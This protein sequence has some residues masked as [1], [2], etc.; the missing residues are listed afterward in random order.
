MYPIIF[1]YKFISIAGYGIMLGLAFYLSFLLLEKELGIKN[2]DQ[3]LAY[4][5][6]LTVIPSGIVGAKLFHILDNFNLFINNPAGMIFSGSGLSVYGGV[7]LA[8][9]ISIFIIKKNNENIMSVLDA[10]AVVVTLGY[11]IGRL[12]CH[13]AGDG[14]YGITTA[15]FLGIAY[16]NGIVPTSI[17]VFPTPLFESFASFI[18]LFFLLHLRKREL[19]HGK[20]FFIYLMLN[21]LVRFLVEFIRLNEK[22]VIIF[23]QAQI[24]AI[25]FILTGL[26]GFI[27]IGKKTRE[28]V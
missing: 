24:I 3:E 25:L 15:S 21:G 23:T 4:K 17:E 18:I 20:L 19:Q 10:M 27:F 28:A 9:G 16:P 22:T 13:V 6:L 14:C 12:G 1:S 11:G 7:I 5:I 2:I 26:C 8:I